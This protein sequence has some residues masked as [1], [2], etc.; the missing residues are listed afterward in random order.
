MWGAWAN[1]LE[2]T[3]TGITSN[4]DVL[5]MRGGYAVTQS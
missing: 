1:F 3:V 5:P 4:R 2:M